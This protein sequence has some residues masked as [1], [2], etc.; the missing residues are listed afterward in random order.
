MKARVHG[1]FLVWGILWVSN[2]RLDGY[3]SHL[4]GSAA[5]AK[6][7]AVSGCKLMVFPTRARARR[8]IEDNYSYIRQRRD[9]R[10]EP[11]GWKMPRAVRVRMSVETDG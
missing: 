5:I 9:L 11:H 2:N 7:E 4:M 3:R 10:E 1:S 6:P 8:Y